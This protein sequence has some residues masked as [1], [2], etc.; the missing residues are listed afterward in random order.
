MFSRPGLSWLVTLVFLAVVD[1]GLGFIAPFL[2]LVVGALIVAPITAMRP[3]LT[4]VLAI[5]FLMLPIVFEVAGISVQFPIAAAIGLGLLLAFWRRTRTLIPLVIL[6]L[7]ASALLTASLIFHER[8]VVADSTAQNGLIA[9]LICLGMVFAVALAR[10]NVIPLLVSIAASGAV[11]STYGLIFGALSVTNRLE[12]EQ[13]NANGTGHVAA[14]AVISAISLAWATKEAW[15]LLLSGPSVVVLSMAHSRAAFIVLAVGLGALV[16][17][18]MRSKARYLLSAALTVLVFI[19]VWT[20]AQEFVSRLFTAGRSEAAA[21]SSTSQRLVLSD[22]AMCLVQ[23]HPLFGIGYRAFPDHSYEIFHVGFNTH[24]DYLRI[25][26]EAGL[27]TLIIVV[28]IGLGATFWT[29]RSWKFRPVVLPIVAA[30]ATSFLYGNTMA[31]LSL[32]FPMWVLLGVLWSRYS[33]GSVL[34]WF[35][36]L[37]SRVFERRRGPGP[38]DNGHHDTT[39]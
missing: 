33:S 10:P 37:K 18:S 5:P 31:L 22:L 21:E 19:S 7:V 39:A 4:L 1:I 17:A 14:I 24:N 20:P 16:I 25:A 9:L 35:R 38:H 36:Q 8:I 34:L 13:L 11:V 29:S 2:S 6:G 12:S 3:Q 30:T 27:P 15:W 28:L 23:S 32:S 26:V